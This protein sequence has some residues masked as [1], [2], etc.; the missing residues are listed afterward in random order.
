M[1]T[2]YSK[3]SDEVEAVDGDSAVAALDEQRRTVLLEIEDKAFSYFRLRAGIVAAEQALHLYRKHRSSMMLRASAA[4]QVINWGAYRGLATQPDM[5][6]EVLIGIG[7]DGSSKLAQEMSKGTRFQLYL[8]LRVAGYHEFAQSRTPVP[9]I[10]DDIMKTFD[11]FRAVNAFRLFADIA[12]VGQVIYLTHHQHLCDI[13]RR[14]CPNARI[15]ELAVPLVPE[16]WRCVRRPIPG[17]SLSRPAGPATSTRQPGSA[18]KGPRPSY[19]L[20]P[21]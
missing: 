13:A 3:A 2:A 21:S 8:A 17:L 4:F 14:V 18:P 5:D 20:H 16:R 1:F 12:K 10:A 6:T 19:V 11:D 9:F 15:H 7:A